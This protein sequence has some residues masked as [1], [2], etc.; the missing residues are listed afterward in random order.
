VGFFALLVP[1]VILQTIGTGAMIRAIMQEYLDRPVRFGESF[2]FALSRFGSLL[3]ASLLAGLIILL[4]TIACLLPGI[5]FAIVY[6]MVSQVVIVEDQGGMDA[7]KRSKSLV[8]GHFGRAL[9]LFFIVGLCT[10]VLSGGVSM[11]AALALP[12]EAA[13][14]PFNPFSTQLVSYPNYAI[15]MTITTLVQIVAQTFTAICTT[16]LYFDLRNRKEAFDLEL[17]ADKLSAWTER[18][19]STSHLPSTAIQQPD[20]GIQPSSTGSKPPSTG[21][22]A[23]DSGTPPSGAKPLP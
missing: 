21:I 6:S 9:G 19:R 14:S 4:G 12:Y 13:R 16:L 20:G 23:A 2:Q 22:Q 5:Y 1:S 8:D 10:A 15:N 17:E 18:F 3:G 7:L 11:T